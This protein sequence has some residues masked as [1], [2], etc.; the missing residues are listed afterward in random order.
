MGTTPNKGIEAT[1]SENI[2]KNISKF[3]NNFNMFADIDNVI[4]IEEIELN[5]SL[6]FL[7]NQS[8]DPTLIQYQDPTLAQTPTSI[9]TT[10]TPTQANET[11]FEENFNQ[12]QQPISVQY[13]QGHSITIEM[14]KT[15]QELGVNEVLVQ[16]ENFEN[17]PISPVDSGNGTHDSDSEDG[18]SG[19]KDFAMDESSEDSDSEGGEENK[20]K[21]KIVKT[22]KNN[23][24]KKLKMWQIKT[25]FSDP[26][27]EA[28]R[29]RAIQAR[30]NRERSKQNKQGLQEKYD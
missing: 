18:S 25:K 17:V 4:P 9:P 1:R 19:N 11:M 15:L 8:Q 30:K 29:Q 16:N 5:E 2:L 13:N 27:K 12:I 20:K 23:S 3:N 6:A 28:K 26:V 7:L 14:S 21:K 10:L 22:G 24:G